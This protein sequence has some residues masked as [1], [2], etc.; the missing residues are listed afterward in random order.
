[1]SDRPRRRVVPWE[2][3]R[4]AGI[5]RRPLRSKESTV[6]ERAS[7]S[8]GAQASRLHLAR[9]NRG[10]VSLRESSSRPLGAPAARRHL[11]RLPGA[12]FFVFEAKTRLD[13]ASPS[14]TRLHEAAGA[15]KREAPRRER[16]ESSRYATPRSTSR[17]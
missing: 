6:S 9:A 1:M 8:L 4:L 17:R 16:H 11:Q 12:F 10:F 7:S 5:L 13:E 14:K 3:R 15:K 2:R